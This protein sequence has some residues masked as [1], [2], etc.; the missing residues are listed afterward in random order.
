VGTFIC[1]ID[2]INPSL[3]FSPRT[4]IPLA[5]LR[6]LIASTPSFFGRLE[7]LDPTAADDWTLDRYRDR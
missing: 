3:P 2:S 4:S 5:V 7:S 6:P 1:L